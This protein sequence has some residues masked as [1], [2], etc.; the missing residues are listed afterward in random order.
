MMDQGPAARPPGFP[1]MKLASA[2][3]SAFAQ[4][5]SLTTS[6]M[7]GAS[8]PACIAPFSVKIADSALPLH[9]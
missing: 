4:R 5:G 7:G 2:A 3:A 8:F 1:L 9:A 6:G